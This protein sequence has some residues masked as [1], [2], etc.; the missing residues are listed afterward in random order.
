MNNCVYLANAEKM[1][2]NGLLKIKRE[3]LDDIKHNSTFNNTCH[4]LI[5][6]SSIT[7]EHTYTQKHW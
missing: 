6:E 3:N 1:V 5:L 2:L 4:N 7:L